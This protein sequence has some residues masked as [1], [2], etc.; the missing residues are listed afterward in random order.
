MSADSALT[1]VAVYTAVLGTYGDAGNAA[2]LSARA[3]QHGLSAQ[4]PGHRTLCARSRQ[5]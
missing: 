4:V 3:R 2:V 1:I 5:R